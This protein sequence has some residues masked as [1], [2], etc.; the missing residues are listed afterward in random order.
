MTPVLPVKIIFI[1][2]N[3]VWKKDEKIEVGVGSEKHDYDRRTE[4]TYLWFGEG[5]KYL[6]SHTIA[7]KSSS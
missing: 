2:L 3:V 7:D 1:L 6:S 5:R 4:T